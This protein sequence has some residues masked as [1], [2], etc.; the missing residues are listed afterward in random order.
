MGKKKHALKALNVVAN[1]QILGQA[2]YHGSVGEGWVAWMGFGT[3]FGSARVGSRG[4]QGG[5][6]SLAPGIKKTSY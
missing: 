2:L 3:G 5:A 6:V 1:V 4:D